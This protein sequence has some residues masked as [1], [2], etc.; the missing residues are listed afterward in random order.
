[1]PAAGGVVLGNM[2]D[3]VD[4]GRGVELVADLNLASTPDNLVLVLYQDGVE[5][6]RAR[7]SRLSYRT[8]RPGAY[9]VEASVE[10][11][12]LPWTRVE[13]V[14]LYSNPIYVM[15]SK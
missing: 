12:G 7:G 13:R 14:F 3:T 6:L 10:T 1:M 5:V 2:G 8:E 11:Q 9:R 15:E 4:L